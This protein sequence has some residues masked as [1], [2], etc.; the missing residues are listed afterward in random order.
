[1]TKSHKSSR[2][3]SE[4][5]G[6]WTAL[7]VIPG[8]AGVVLAEVGQWVSPEVT[9]FLAFFGLLYPFSFFFLVVGTALRLVNGQW[10]KVLV[11][12]AI[13][14]WTAPQAG[15]TWG[16][17]QDGGEAEGD[18]SIEVMS[19]NVRQFDRYDWLGGER[20]K[21]DVLAVIREVGAEVV[22]LQ[23]AYVADGFLTMRQVER[24]AGVEDVHASFGRRGDPS[25]HFGLLTLSRLPM[26]RRETLRFEEDP[27]N[28]CLV[29][30]LEVEGD[31]IRVF[32]V[33]LSSIRFE[34]SDYEAVRRGPDAEERARLWGRLSRAW[35]KRAEQARQIADAV[36]ASP[37]PVLVMGDF[38]DGPVSY[39][40]DQFSE[41]LS[42]AFAVEGS[43]LG[44]T[45]I[46]DLPTLRIDYVLFGKPFVPTQF[47][48]LREELSDHRAVRAAFKW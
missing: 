32:N 35:V 10:L 25:R 45:Y 3:Q 12:A 44:A 48:T 21:D 28:G 8:A 30:D 29:T 1:M 27:G 38:N 34:A 36:A 2:K 26:V 13:L 46:G 4:P 31:T 43:G 14:L 6:R 37:H 16:G 47:E 22:C 33:H 9:T 18:R 11:P 39:A 20:V 15:R 41:G 23:E 19:W 5:R 42:D 24:A 7:L 40:L 17:W